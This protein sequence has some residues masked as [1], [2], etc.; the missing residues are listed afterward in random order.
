MQLEDN[1]KEE[2]F[3]Q[4]M[5]TYERFLLE[6]GEVNDSYNTACSKTEVSDSEIQKLVDSI[7][8][9]KLPFKL[10]SSEKIELRKNFYKN[11]TI[12]QRIEMFKGDRDMEIAPSI[13]AFKDNPEKYYIPGI[14]DPLP[15]GIRIQ[16]NIGMGEILMYLENSDGDKLISDLTAKS[17]VNTGEYEPEQI[18]VMKD[19]WEASSEYETEHVKWYEEQSKVENLILMDDVEDLYDMSEVFEIDMRAWYKKLDNDDKEDWDDSDIRNE[20]RY[21]SGKYDEALKQYVNDWNGEIMDILEESNDLQFDED[22]ELFHE[23]ASSNINT[24]GDMQI[25]IGQVNSKLRG[26]GLYSFMRRE[27]FNYADTENRSVSTTAAP[28]HYMSNYIATVSNNLYANYKHGMITK[29]Y[30]SFGESDINGSKVVRYPH[31]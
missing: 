5:R 9:R 29:Y 18:E 23:W 24:Q 17:N 22:G 31:K 3:I 1:E 20:F 26:L 14:N 7:L 12:K 10:S 8:S 2:E 25:G 15:E 11:T 28:K 30:A 27:L 16:N 13:E 6:N 19:H 21:H 4:R